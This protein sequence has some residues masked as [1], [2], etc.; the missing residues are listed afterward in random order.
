VFLFLDRLPR[1]STN[2]VD[3]QSLKHQFEQSFARPV[4]TA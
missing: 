4:N 3:Y 1:T 2:K